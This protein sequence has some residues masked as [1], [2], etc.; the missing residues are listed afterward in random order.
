MPLISDASAIFLGTT[1]VNAIYVKDTLVWPMDVGIQSITLVSAI[2]IVATY[3]C[4]M[5]DGSLAPD[6]SI[7]VLI[8][9]PS[10]EDI[11]GGSQNWLQL[12]TVNVIDGYAVIDLTNTTYDI[13]EC[14]TV[15]PYASE[16]IRGPWQGLPTNGDRFI[17]T[18]Y[19]SNLDRSDYREIQ[20]GE[21]G[22][23]R[24]NYDSSRVLDEQATMS[25]ASGLTRQNA[26]VA[27]IDE[28]DR[29]L[30]SSS[31]LPTEMGRWTVGA[32]GSIWKW[33]EGSQPNGGYL[34]SMPNHNE[35]M[36]AST[37]L[38]TGPLPYGQ[39]RIFLPAGTTNITAKEYPDTGWIL[40]T[41]N[42]TW[43][44]GGALGYKDC[45]WTPPAI[46]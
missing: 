27:I 17:L 29:E 39:A 24:N 16:E 18:H 12:S 20:I 5:G 1:P 46:V 9:H 38:L 7:G 2:G 44:Y 8:H 15:Q 14:V 13:T 35:G 19:G 31:G 3:E 25:Y 36:N 37:I 43:R 11:A 40:R 34:H 21:D 6:Q 22:L 10:L 42:I 4:R 28:S 32:A 23:V 26:N 45:V 33:N 30:Y 41:S